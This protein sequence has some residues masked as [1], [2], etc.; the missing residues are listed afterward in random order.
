MFVAGIRQSKFRH[1]VGRTSHRS[2]H[3]DN[4]RNL[5]QNVTGESDGFHVNP[6]RCAIPLKGTSGLVAV[7]EVRL[8]IVK[9]APSLPVRSQK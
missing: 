5:S 8:N 6:Y 7:L 1:L 3:I 2:Q 4:V 9:T